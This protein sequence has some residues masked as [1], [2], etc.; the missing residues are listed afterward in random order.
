MKTKALH[1]LLASLSLCWTIAPAA[2]KAAPPTRIPP[3]A[4]IA[5]IKIGYTTREQLEKQ[6]GKG[7]AVL[8]GH[9]NGARQWRVKGTAWLLYADAFDYAQNG[10]VLNRMDLSVAPKGDS[11]MPFARVTTNKLV[12]LDGV[13]LGMSKEKV[14]ELLNRHSLSPRQKEG[15]IEASASGFYQLN[16]E[17]YEL[18]TAEFKFSTNGLIWFSLKAEMKPHS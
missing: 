9:P 3:C 4:E 8:G 5:G 6:W 14:M 1:S 11:R 15:R 12:W 7:R 17:T 13:C 2:Q 16:Q 10:I 18:W